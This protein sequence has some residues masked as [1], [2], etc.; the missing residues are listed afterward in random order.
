[1]KEFIKC[2]LVGFFVLLLL[3]LILFSLCTFH[4]YLISKIISLIVLVGIGI[5][6]CFVCGA[7]CLGKGGGECGGA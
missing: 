1:M 7:L 5:F 3:T 6:L 4:V 2:F